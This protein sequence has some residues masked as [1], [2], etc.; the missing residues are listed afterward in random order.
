MAQTGDFK[1]AQMLV[2]ELNKDHLTDTLI[3]KYWIP[4]I[5]A[6][7]ELRQ[8]T[9]SKALETLSV[10]APFDFAASPALTVSTLYPAYVRGEI[11]LAAGDGRRAVA[12][13]NKLIDH[14]GMVLN[15]PLGA[16]AHLGR[17]R[18]YALTDDWARAHDSYQEFFQLWKGADSDL[19]LLRQAR[20]EFSK[21]TQ[22]SIVSPQVDRVPLK[23]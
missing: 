3:Q 4:T 19:S 15:F 9:W 17:A 7:M 11:Y 20:A 22:S 23:H 2:E 12:E 5:R 14:P 21:L 13:Y 1:R 10:A 16:L 6:R 8:G 18:A